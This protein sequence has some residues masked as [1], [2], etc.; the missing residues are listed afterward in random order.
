M[1]CPTV[2]IL[3]Q[4]PTALFETLRSLDYGS[5]TTGYASLGSPCDHAVSEFIISNTMGVGVTLSTDGATNLLYVPA[6][7]VKSYRFAEKGLRFPKL[8]QFYV[9]RDAGSP[10]S[11]GVYLEVMYG[12]GS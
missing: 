5:I 2:Q 4:S 10:S 9:K 6:G 3:N 12:K 7:T 8:S 11:G 1:A